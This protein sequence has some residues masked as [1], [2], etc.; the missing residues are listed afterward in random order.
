M[1]S[2]G[3]MIAAAW[4]IDHS[5]DGS[6][7]PSDYWVINQAWI[8]LSMELPLTGPVQRWTTRWKKKKEEEALGLNPEVGLSTVKKK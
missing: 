4:L 5:N 1:H 8:T 2:S 7:D 3:L 6:E